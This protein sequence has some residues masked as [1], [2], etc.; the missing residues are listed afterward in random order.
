MFGN[1]VPAGRP[2]RVDASMGGGFLFSMM[3]APKLFKSFLRS[4][5]HGSDRNY[6]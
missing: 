3:I 2:R 1:M 4:G 6:S 5:V